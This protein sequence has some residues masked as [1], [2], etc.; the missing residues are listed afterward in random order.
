MLLEVLVLIPLVRSKLSFCIKTSKSM[1]K[2][3]QSYGQLCVWL[4]KLFDIQPEFYSP[5]CNFC[6]TTAL[7]FF[8]WEIQSIGRDGGGPSGLG[9]KWVYTEK[10]PVHEGWQV[11]RSLV[12]L[13]FSW[14]WLGYFTQSGA[15]V[16]QYSVL[17]VI[18]WGGRWG[19]RNFLAL[20]MCVVI[21][22][23]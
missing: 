8:S 18:F 17:F 4:H 23:L 10:A 13:A 12:V 1:L 22:G 6:M 11:Y 3:K 9:K 21:F 5:Y 2:L 15:T 14:C 7:I 20:L 19:R 16:A